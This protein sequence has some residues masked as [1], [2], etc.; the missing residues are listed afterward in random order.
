M[1]QHNIL[2]SVYGLETDYFDRFFYDFSLVAHDIY[3]Y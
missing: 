2:E 3:E 1:L